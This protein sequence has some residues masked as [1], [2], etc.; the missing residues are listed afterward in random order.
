MTTHDATRAPALVFGGTFDP[1]HRVHVRMATAAAD[2]L[3]ARA[4]LVIPA[5]INPQRAASPP[6]PA[7]DRRAMTLAAFADEPRAR[8]LDLELERHGPSY[9]IDTVR[10]LHDQGAA[11][12][13]LLIGSDQ[14]L[15]FPTW[16]AWREVAELAPPAIVVRPPQTHATLLGELRRV[17]GAE[18]EAWAARIL[19]IP[20]TDM[21][22][23]DARA[24][25]ARGEAP[26]ALDP[27]ILAYIR[28][29]GLYGVPPSQSS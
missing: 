29:H 8:V 17:F 28:R 9:T 6:A 15:N 4:I 27:A 16:R 10:A 19:P 22:A 24:A 20:P 26:D 11:P 18:A 2:C 25:L 13:R 23:T 14:A 21:S 12:L 3:G 7:A 1:P 5:A